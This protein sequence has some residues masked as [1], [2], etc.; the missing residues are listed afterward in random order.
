MKEGE[1]ARIEVDYARKRG[2]IEGRRMADIISQRIAFGSLEIVAETDKGP[3]HA[4]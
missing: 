2:D 3:A 1:K 4:G